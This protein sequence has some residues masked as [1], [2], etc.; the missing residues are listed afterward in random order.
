M[1]RFNKIPNK[2]HNKS[3]NKTFFSIIYLLRIPN[4]RGLLTSLA[5]SVAAITSFAQTVPSANPADTYPSKPIRIVVP[6]AAG[7]TVDI[8][9]RAVAL[10]L[11][12]SLGQP[13]LVENRP[14]AAS[15]VGT[16]SVAHAAPDGYTLLASSG[17]F[18]SAAV[19]LPNA[20]YDPIKDFAPVSLTC[21]VPMLMITSPD[22]PAKN[23]GELVKYAKLH[24]SEISAA[25]SGNGSTGHI[26]SEVF[27]S[28]AGVKFLNVFYKGNSQAMVDVMGGQ[29]N[30]MFDQISTAGV[31]YKTGK[32]K[33]LAITSLKRSPLFP[34]IPTIS[35]SGYQGYEDV[36]LNF[37]LAP[38]G[39][40]KEITTKLNF[41][42]Q[43]IFKNKELI[44]RFAEKGIDLTAS[45]ST[46]DFKAMI[47]SEVDRLTLLVSTAGI[48]PE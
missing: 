8:V 22:T 40:P 31:Q 34:E 38:A 44:S 11:S 28:R 24:P 36:T 10:E 35:E 3:A 1:K 32:L 48:K 27:A 39:T 42:I 30:L 33:A 16:L 14:S 21:K 9:A 19:I 45:P 15:L 18:L 37:I 6:V 17:T 47:K 46:D 5:L 2:P 25:S 12:K 23:I 29:A 41:E 20:G 43:K 7:G 4:L 13:V 26:A